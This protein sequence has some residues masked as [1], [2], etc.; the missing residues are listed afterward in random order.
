MCNTHTHRVLNNE[1]LKQVVRIWAN[2]PNLVY[3]E[4]EKGHLMGKQMTFQKDK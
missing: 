4:E 2:A 3:E 1:K